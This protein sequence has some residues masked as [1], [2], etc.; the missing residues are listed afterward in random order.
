V[1]S[2]DAPALAA[3]TRRRTDGR[4]LP[5]RSLAD[6]L[7]ALDPNV[8][9]V[10]GRLEDEVWIFSRV[11]VGRA[12][13]VAAV[14]A[15]AA[16]EI[17]DD[18]PGFEW[19]E[20]LSEQ[21]VEWDEVAVDL[22]AGEICS[23]GTAR[24]SFDAFALLPGYLA[25]LV[26]SQG[27]TLH[28]APR[29]FILGPA[30]SSGRRSAVG[31]PPQRLDDEDG[32][33]LW[34]PKIDFHLETVPLHGMARIH[35]ELSV[36]RF[37]LQRV[38]YV[39]DHGTG[40]PAAMI[41][42]HARDGFLRAS[43]QPTVVG[44]VAYKRRVGGRLRWTWGHGLARA[45]AR[46][47]DHRRR[48]GLTSSHSR[49]TTTG[50]SRSIPTTSRSDRRASC[51]PNGDQSQVRSDASRTVRGDRDPPRTGRPT[52]CPGRCRRARRTRRGRA[53]AHPG[54]GRPAAGAG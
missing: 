8:L 32:P 20:I 17:T 35:A 51:R 1:A 38:A 49:G 52:A 11:P 19:L 43:E 39:P 12:V 41:W 18:R 48:R 42:L 9:H 7:G 21:A 13:I 29:S 3:N 16:T 23:N 44:A 25:A 15:W 6:L 33:A 50:P 2:D 30:D 47:T 53:A 46:L 14:E 27:V 45:L 54:R 31:W 10:S 34:T 26:A 24:P 28:D 4:S 22:L 36:T 40:P 37:P 5:A